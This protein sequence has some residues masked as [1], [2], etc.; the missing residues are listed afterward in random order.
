MNILVCISSVPDTTSP[1]NFNNDN[2]AFDTNGITFIINPYDEFCLTKAIF[3]K[4]QTGALITVLN[5]GE[6]NNDSVLRKA[7]AIG[8]DKAVRINQAPKNS[9]MVSELIADYCKKNTFDLI[10]CG[11]ESIDYNGGKVPGFLAEKLNIPFI[12]GC[13]GMEIN[14]ESLELKREIDNGYEICVSSLPALI[15]GQKGLVEEK[16]LKIP[17]MRGI[18]TARTKPL[19]ILDSEIEFQEKITIINFEKPLGKSECKLINDNEVE[20]LVDLLANEAKV[21]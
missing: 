16:D 9:K 20:K 17:S 13:I 12:N 6:Q 15:A 14:G 18:M 8:A 10:L 1:I 19:E 2:N 7:L 21:I 5:V 11:R 3:I 4:E